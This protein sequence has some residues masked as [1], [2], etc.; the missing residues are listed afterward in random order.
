[1]AEL[2]VFGRLV[3]SRPCTPAA[4]A[5]E[6]NGAALDAQAA[7][8]AAPEDLV[9]PEGNENWAKFAMKWGCRWRKAAASTARS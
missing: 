4:Q 2:V 7:D 5:G 8:G 6:A 3:G 1:M 9:N